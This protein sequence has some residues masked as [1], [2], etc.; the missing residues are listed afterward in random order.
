M[1]KTISLADDAYAALSR[2]KRPGESFS[3]VTRRLVHEHGRRTLLELAGTWSMSEDDTREFLADIYRRRDE[4]L[5]PP[6]SF[7]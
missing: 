6:V 5:R 2:T 3:D 4:S 1:T 7:E